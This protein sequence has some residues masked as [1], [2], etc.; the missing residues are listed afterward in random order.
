MRCSCYIISFKNSYK[1]Q[2]QY[3]VLVDTWT[4]DFAKKYNNTRPILTLYL[5]CIITNYIN[6]P[7]ICTFCM[8][9]FYN[10]CTTLHVWNDHFLHHQEF[11]IY[12][13]CGSVQTIQTC[14]VRPYVRRTHWASYTRLHG[15]YRAADTVNHELLM[16]NE[17]VVPN[18]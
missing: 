12:C 2:L 5:P 3:L 10:F 13:I 18:M 14:S 15:L 8:Y 7:T 16:M 17:M 1:L 6:K 11:M 9:L 4:T